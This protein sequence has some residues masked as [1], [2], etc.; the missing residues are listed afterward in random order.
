MNNDLKKILRDLRRGKETPASLQLNIGEDGALKFK[1][2]DGYTPQKGIDYWTPEEVNAITQ[3]IFDAA[4]PRKG[5]DYYTDQDKRSF[6][7]E[8]LK[9]ATP[10]KGRDYR[11]GR[12]GIDGRDG[13]DAE[14]VD[15]RKV[16]IDAINFLESFE[17]DARLSA[18]ALKDLDEAVTEILQKGADFELSEK[19]ITTIKDLLPKYPPMNAGGS[20]AT[21]LKSL[22]DVDL[23]GLTKNADGKYVLGGGTG[24]STFLALTD[25]PAAY[26]GQAGKLAA[27]NTGETGIE[28]VEDNSLIN[29]IIFG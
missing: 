28:F 1:G 14:E 22:R 19:Q 16:A 7:A 25:T 13:K 10:V 12:D 29:A 4:R 15:A 21:F 17:G 26:T 23:S 27:V 24:S 3:A 18:K 9:L 20:G 5:V 11:D 8:V 6:V 2:Q